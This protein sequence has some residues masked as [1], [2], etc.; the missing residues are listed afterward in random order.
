MTKK[1]K[2]LQ[3][4]L[5]SLRKLGGIIRLSEALRLGIHRRDFYKLRDAGELEMISRGSVSIYN[6][7]LS[8][9]RILR[10]FRRVFK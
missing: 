8:I 9:D 10:S 3:T 1:D 2:K 5:R 6:I 7:F 4:T